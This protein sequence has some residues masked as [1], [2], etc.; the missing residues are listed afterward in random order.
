MQAYILK[1]DAV[2]SPWGEPVGQALVL[3]EPVVDH[4]AGVLRQAGAAQVSQVTEVP[5]S[6]GAERL[7][8]TDDLWLTVHLVRAFLKAA[9]A[10][11]KPSVLVLKEGLFTSYSHALQDLGQVEDGRR[12]PLVYLPAGS[13]WRPSGDLA[14]DEQGLEPVVIDP[15]ASPLELPMHPAVIKEG[16]LVLPMAHLAALRLAHWMHIVRANQLA[17]L[18]WGSALFKVEPLKLLW[19]LVRAMSFNKWKIMGKLTRAGKGCDIHPSAVVEASTLGDNVVVGANAVV[20]FSHLGDGVRISDQCNI[21]YSVLGQGASVA[22]MGMLQG[23]VIYP[24]SNS[25]HYGLQLCVVGR[26]TF[27]GGEVVLGDF[28]PAGEIMV[29]HRGKLVSARTNMLGCAVGHGCQILMRATTYAGREIP[30]GYWILGPPHDI[31]AKIPAA[32][33]T[34]EPLIADGGVLT[35]YAE[36]MRRRKGQD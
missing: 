18:A 23:C 33:P 24:G 3:N 19:A 20:R 21:Q 26:D 13:D 9:R 28:K 1:T 14:L 6:H 15:E 34:G 10:T 7:L 31:I 32:L 8:A 16:R 2:L 30:N 29:M 35:P 5:Q 27:V 12:Y 25:G 22:R 17:L 11:G 4:L 36:V